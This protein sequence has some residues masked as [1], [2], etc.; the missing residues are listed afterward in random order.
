MEYV[1]TPMLPLVTVKGSPAD[2]ARLCMQVFVANCP[3]VWVLI[4]LLYVA[5]HMLQGMRLIDATSLTLIGM[6]DSPE[7]YLPMN[8]GV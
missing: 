2:R 8:L 1:L 3:A 4:V 7:S 6:N 5:E